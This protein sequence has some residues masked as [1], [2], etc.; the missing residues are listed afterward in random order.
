MISIY[1]FLI[2]YAVNMHNVNQVTY[3][4][5]IYFKGNTLIEVIKM[6]KHCIVKCRF[7]KNGICKNKAILNFGKN[8]CPFEINTVD[9][10]N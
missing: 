9:I 7:N 10:K 5:E 2:I 8:F 4:I 3:Y 6:I 1:L